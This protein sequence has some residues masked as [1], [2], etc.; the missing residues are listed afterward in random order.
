MNP[1]AVK[2]I[3]F[4]FAAVAEDGDAAGFVATGAAMGCEAAADAPASF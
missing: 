2:W 1:E 3:T 4:L